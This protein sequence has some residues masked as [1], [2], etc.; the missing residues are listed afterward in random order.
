MYHGV[1]GGIAVY[2]VQPG[3]TCKDAKNL[4]FYMG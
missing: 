3:L 4:N 2:S 1:S